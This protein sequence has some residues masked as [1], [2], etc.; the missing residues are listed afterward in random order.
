MFENDFRLV[1]VSHK[2]W[3]LNHWT[4]GIYKFLWWLIEISD[5]NRYSTF[6]HRNKTFNSSDIFVNSG[7]QWYYRV[8][9]SIFYSRVPNSSWLF[10][11]P[12]N[13]SAKYLKW[14]TLL[15]SQCK[16][17]KRERVQKLRITERNGWHWLRQKEQQSDTLGADQPGPGCCETSSGPTPQASTAPSI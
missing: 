3:R 7:K 2:I 17:P 13:S 14:V 10:Q 15:K 12:G 9:R 8:S 4:V 16:K 1:K 11:K 6:N 5:Q